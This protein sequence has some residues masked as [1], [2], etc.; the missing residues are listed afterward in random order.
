MH[1]ELLI[2]GL[3][4]QTAPIELRE[5]L[6][7]SSKDLPAE[8][9]RLS[10]LGTMSESVLLSTCNRVEVVAAASDLAAASNALKHYFAQRAG[11]MD[12]VA[13]YLYEKSGDEAVRHLLRVTAGLEA[14][15]IGEPQILG[16]VKEALV[17]AQ[18]AATIG[19]QLSRAFARAFA[20][21]KRIRTE[22]DI[23]QGRISVSSIACEL[24][25][26][27]LGDL[28]GKKVLL[29]GAGKM[30]LESARTLTAHGADLLVVN[31]S[32]ERA[33]ELAVLS[34]AH[35]QLLE[36]LSDGLERADVVIS[37]TSHPGLVI[38]VEA[39]EAAL[40]IR[41][42]RRL[43]IIDIA[44][45]RD[46]DP[47]VADLENVFLYNIDDLQDV[48][49]TNLAERK[50]EIPAAEAII[51]EAVRQFRRWQTSLM[52]TPTIVAL[53]ER[54]RETVLTER[55]RA[56]G[57][58]G[59]LSEKERAALDLMCEAIVNKLLHQPLTQL[60]RGCQEPDQL[61]LVTAAQQ[62]FALSVTEASDEEAPVCEEGS[63]RA[64]VSVFPETSREP[65]FSSAQTGQLSARKRRA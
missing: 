7:V 19:S 8:L 17:A 16:Q 58:L 26:E 42:G 44:V 51:E 49:K 20:I 60:K 59:A 14:I 39:I 3:S 48:S 54:F 1:P 47:R 56:L 15:A 34:G 62:L 52:L 46:V 5:K 57:R 6:S 18:R 32:V 61:E 63:G 4:H 64:S 13:D 23:A 30:S 53:R 50:R 29:V 9:A 36:S 27:C 12:D 45:P 28:R 2:I 25:R 21:A 38:T 40:R 10:G 35:P 24:A 11:S 31:R 41:Q 33:R 22:T 55:D 65:V 37:S 43:F